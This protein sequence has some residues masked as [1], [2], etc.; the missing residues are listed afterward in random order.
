LVPKIQ[1]GKDAKGLIGEVEDRFSICPG[2]SQIYTRTVTG[3]RHK[4]LVAWIGRINQSEE[5]GF[6][7]REDAGYD[8][9]ACGYMQE[10]I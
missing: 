3:S 10:A 5:V 9:E 4:A 1:P 8:V 2:A 7:A 6:H